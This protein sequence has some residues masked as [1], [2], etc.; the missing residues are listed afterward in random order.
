MRDVDLNM[1]D[2]DG[3]T[4]LHLCAAEGHMDC[5]KFLLEVCKV[6]PDPKDR[7]RNIPCKNTFPWLTMSVIICRWSNTPLSEA[8][9]FQHPRIAMYL[10]DFI[11]KNPT[12]GVD[13]MNNHFGGDGDG[14]S[15]K[16]NSP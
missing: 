5:V 2:Y 10:K 6:Y 3:R 7:C 13:T 12:Q 15:K 16:W 4:A 14:K 9:R 1:S 11:K 8:L